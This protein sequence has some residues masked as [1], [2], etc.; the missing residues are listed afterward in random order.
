MGGTTLQNVLFAVGG[1]VVTA[2]VFAARR[3]LAALARLLLDFAYTRLAGSALLRR[4]ALAKYTRA[5][6]DRHRRFA[7]SFQVDEDLK[8]PMESVYVPLRGAR[9][10]G[11]PTELAADLRAERH[12]V[13][14][15]V[16][17]AG[18]TM[19]LRHQV[20]MWARER[21]RGAAA[22][23]G[24]P[25]GNG[26]TRRKPGRERRPRV[27]LGDLGDIPVL[28]EL[29]WLNKAPE[30]SIEKHLVDHFAR[31]DFPGAE[32]WVTRAL[33]RGSL[34]LYFDGLDEVTTELR[35]LVADRIEE[36]T[37]KY[38]A[39]RVV[40]TCRTAVYEGWFA[41]SFGQT[42]RVRDFDEHLIRRFLN[43]WPWRP[44]TALE[45]ESTVD[46]VLGALRDTPQIMALARN[47]LLLTMI[48]YLYDF[49][50]AGTDQV[51]PHTRAEF[52]KQVID[53]LLIDRRRKSVYPF[54]LKKAVLQEV[55]LVAQDIPSG[56]HDRLALPHE[57][58]LETVRA[59]LER[60]ARDPGAA[61][62]VLN[63]IVH[64]SGLLLAVDNGERYQFAH[65][66]LQEYLAAVKLAADPT[67]LLRRYRDDPA[68]WRET[69]RLWC[70]V[71][72]RDCTEVVRTVFTRDPVLAFQCLADAHT[73]EDGLAEE[74]LEHFR[75][76]LGGE[77]GVLDEAVINAF[78]LVGSDGRRRGRSVF[79]FL[80]E[81]VR[82]DTD[83]DRVR[84]AAHALAATSLPKAAE[85]L[86]TMAEP[87]NAAW[88]GLQTMGDLA[89][90]AYQDMAADHVEAVR[91]LW[92]IRTPKAALALNHVLWHPTDPTTRLSC[93]FHLGEL[94][95]VPEIAD[96]LRTAPVGPS[97]GGNLSW[98]WR[99]FAQGTDDALVMI[100]GKIAA[101]I[102]SADAFVI[103]H[104]EL[105][106]PDPRIIAPLV[107]ISRDV[108]YALRQEVSAGDE[109]ME[110]LRRRSDPRILVQHPVAEDRR[111]DTSVLAQYLEVELPSFGS[112]ILEQAVKALGSTGLTAHRLEL[113]RRLPEWLQ[114]RTAVALLK[115][116]TFAGPPSW[117]VP[118]PEA[119]TRGYDFGR[120]MHYRFIL[121]VCV[122]LSGVAAW[123][124]WT[125]AA[126]GDQPWG[127]AWLP[128]AVLVQI[129]AGWIALIACGSL[130]DP[131]ALFIFGLVGLFAGGIA[132]SQVI[133]DREWAAFRDRGF[134][135]MLGAVGLVPAVCLYSWT[136]LTEA[137]GATAA[138]GVAVG[139]VAAVAG[140]S[141]RGLE[142]QR[143][144]NARTHPIC[145]LVLKPL[146]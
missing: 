51:L 12:S 36:F 32:K 24:A 111:I 103:T 77:H 142:L 13:V 21:V 127:P 124:A 130:T 56:V 95:S 39:C 99:P 115:Q 119:E 68:A 50:Y 43:G 57:T 93:A 54:P 88:N 108:T 37:A 135:C 101:T 134:F 7:V 15:G 125:A 20:L 64:R 144:W 90:S 25:G 48:A 123:R 8:L 22:G 117:D 98:V 79:D 91:A 34:A 5:L 65:L 85:A 81:T 132:V 139:V 105:P 94:L 3:R 100:A 60:Q 26:A 29:H 121:L 55:A 28:L 9:G 87:G 47:P 75:G 126:G 27:D 78:G 40:V 66:T 58:V 69:V 62:K 2:I 122:A 138:T 96:E 107:V 89:V 71:E 136:A 143:R 83:P 38:A 116:Q 131:E 112:F 44:D 30:R 74:I 86:A 128:V 97:R 23:T 114:M 141:T 67:G 10:D 140:A 46:Q 59:V 63:E 17:G 53:S 1:S 145:D 133:R 49:V 33:E 113:L 70:G 109:L 16:P 72:P 52:Y 61:E 73:I 129:A 14:L 118:S 120:S 11:A 41:E 76:A 19:L 106:T 6:Y 4:A 42:L 137:W 18:K 102:D 146:L 45:P 92:S 35:P 84:A 82:S 104:A 80:V 31:H 110:W